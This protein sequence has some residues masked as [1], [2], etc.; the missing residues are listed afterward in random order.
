MESEDAGGLLPSLVLSNPLCSP[1]KM[2]FPAA[3]LPHT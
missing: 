1:V 2:E 3:V